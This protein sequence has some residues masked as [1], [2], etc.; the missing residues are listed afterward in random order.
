[1]RI[2]KISSRRISNRNG[3][4]QIKFVP[5]I[6]TSEMLRNTCPEVKTTKT[7]AFMWNSDVS[8]SIED[9]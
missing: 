4:Q 3:Y 2:K 5:M 8:R 6:S 1:M 7:A 9:T